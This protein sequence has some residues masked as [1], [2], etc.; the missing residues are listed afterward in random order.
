[1]FSFFRKSSQD[2]PAGKMT[3]PVAVK[4]P[5][6]PEARNAATPHAEPPPP[7]T[8]LPLD[9]ATEIVIFEEISAEAC[10][11]VEEAAVYYANNMAEQALATLLGFIQEHPDSKEL[12]PWLMVFD[13]YQVLLNHQ[14]FND[15]S[16]QFVVKFE[17]SAPIWKAP[18]APVAAK[19]TESAQQ[20]NLFSL[21]EHLSAGPDME[22][23]CHLVQGA[24]SARVSVGQVVAVEPEGCRLMQEGLQGCRRKGRVLQLE[25]ADHLAEV[26]KKRIADAGQ[27]EAG[28]LAW[29]LLFELYQWLGREV[30]YE[31]LAI[32]YAVTYEVSPP[33][34]EGLKPAQAAAQKQPPSPAEAAGQVDDD[35]FALHGAI[36]EASQSQLQDLIAF[37]QDHKEVRI[38]LADVPRVDFGAVGNF[39]SVLI[40]LKQEGKTVLIQEAS[41]MVKALF[42]MMGVEEFATL[43][44]RKAH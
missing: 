40:S 35:V 24:E 2:E 19:K 27:G 14:A 12:Q 23:L 32:E 11:V 25:G 44:R 38:S 22:K 33:A 21:G 13:L 41:E 31:D 26:L 28:Q 4:P 36:T 37:A 6:K 30:E 42:H 9:S 29:L 5:V 1:M 43:I 10:S 18:A 8:E 3:A 7:A 15:L 20:K 39:I 34:W 16:M 17:R